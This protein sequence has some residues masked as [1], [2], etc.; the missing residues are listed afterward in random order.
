[1]LMPPIWE[2]KYSLGCVF[3]KTPE[4]LLAMFTLEISVALTF[5]VN[6]ALVPAK[7]AAVTAL[8]L[9]FPALSLF[10]IAFGVFTF[11]GATVQLR[12]RVPVEVTGEPLMAKSD[13]GALNPTLVTVPVPGKDCPLANAIRPLLPIRNP[14]SPAAFEPDP[15]N[16]LSVALGV[17]VLFAKGSACYWKI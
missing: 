12:P 11:V 3:V 5:A 8:A 10:T 2:S 15:N 14:V 4:L 17:F 13:E 9:K 16:K 7:L 1:M 6:A